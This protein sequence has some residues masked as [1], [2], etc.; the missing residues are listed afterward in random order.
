[1]A[2]T[3]TAAPTAA[4]TKAAIGCVMLSVHST[5]PSAGSRSGARFMLLMQAHS[6]RQAAHPIRGMASRYRGRMHFAPAF[7]GALP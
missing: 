1:M 4:P 5:F 7:S 2:Y 3:V 6:A